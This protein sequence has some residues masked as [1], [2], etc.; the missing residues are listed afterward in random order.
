MR[1][2]AVTSV[3][4]NVIGASVAKAHGK[5]WC[6]V[7]RPWHGVWK[8]METSVPQRTIF[9]YFPDRGVAQ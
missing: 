6:H 5:A 7:D 1:T 2:V 3:G 9:G 4:T 8:E